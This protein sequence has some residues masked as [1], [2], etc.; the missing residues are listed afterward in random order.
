MSTYVQSRIQKKGLSYFFP[1][2]KI[3]IKKK[4]IKK[5]HLNSSLWRLKA[6]F[7]YIWQAYPIFNTAI[8]RLTDCCD[9]SGIVTSEQR[10]VL[11]SLTVLRKAE[12]MWAQLF[13]PETSR[14]HRA[15]LHTLKKCFLV[16]SSPQSLILGLIF[17]ILSGNPNDYDIR[18][19]NG[20]IDTT[21]I[22]K[23]EHGFG[24]FWGFSWVWRL[25]FGLC[26]AGQ[27]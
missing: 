14:L 16:S 11:Q 9:R 1:I 17:L 24:L 25:Q 8:S 19:D 4:Q 18:K 22:V 27:T 6:L 15:D 26:T 2:I 23:P 3:I 5:K 21:S 10:T 7:S 12:M 13:I 20:S